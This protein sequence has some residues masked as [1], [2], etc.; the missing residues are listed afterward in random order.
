MAPRPRKVDLRGRHPFRPPRLG[1]E[2]G[3]HPEPLGDR[4]W[5]EVH[6]LPKS[7]GPMHPPSLKHRVRRVTFW[8]DILLVNS[9]EK[10]LLFLRY[11]PPGGDV[12]GG[13]IF[14]APGEECTICPNPDPGGNGIA[15]ATQ[16]FGGGGGGLGFRPTLR[17]CDRLPG[18][19]P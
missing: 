14:G 3:M 12:P 17:E 4:F 7:G 8:G 10:K 9:I 5:R 13:P 2:T 16:T 11:A 18:T 1:G 15:T 19:D 6:F